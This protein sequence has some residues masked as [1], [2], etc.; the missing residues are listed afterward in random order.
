[1]IPSEVV[2]I[3][4]SAFS[5]CKNLKSVQFEEN[6]KLKYIRKEAFC[7]TAL[8]EI[9]IQKNVIEIGD[10]SFANCNKLKDLLFEENLDPDP[11]QVEIGSMAFSKTRL[12]S[13]SF[14]KNVSYIGSGAFSGISEHLE[15]KFDPIDPPSLG[16]DVFK[17]SFIKKLS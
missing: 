12:A 8:T 5:D 15:I 9:V 3:G 17:D 10:G 6:S 13:I 2:E 14:P 16:I 11:V 7:G 4:E 1:M